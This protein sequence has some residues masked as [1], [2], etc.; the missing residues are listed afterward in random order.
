[1]EEENLIVGVDIGT[2]KISAAAG[3]LQNDGSIKIKGFVEKALKPQDEA[4]RN[5]E[6]ENA[7]RTIDILD[8]VLEELAENVG[9]NLIDININIS[10]PEIS[11]TYHKG[12]VTKSGENKQIQQNDVDKLIEDLRLTNR[13]QPGRTLLHSLPQDFYINDVRAGEKIVGKFGIQ[14]GGEFYFVSTPTESLEKLYY[15]IKSVNAKIE[16][17]KQSEPLQIDQIILS[18]VAD[19]MALLDET[20]DDKRNGVAIVN[21]GAEMTEISIFHKNA[22]RHFKAVALG[23]NN[24]NN[25]LSEAFQ[26]NFDDAEILKKISGNIPSKSVS[27]TEV[28]VINRQKDLAPI[29]IQ[30]KNASNVVEWRLKEIAALVKTEIIRSGYE[31]N[32][33]NGIILTGGTSSMAIIKEIFLDVCKIKTVRKAKIN[34]KINFSGFEMLNKPKYSTL[35]GLLIAAYNDFDNRANNSILNHGKVAETAGASLESSKPNV[36]KKIEKENKP[37]F[38]EKIK[39]FI[40]DD[41]LNDDYNN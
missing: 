21:I 16:D 30:L 20:I 1:M 8:E 2:S 25:D 12:K 6:I 24:I 15:T 41:N 13:P 29:E 17:S 34:N 40:K 3:S 36:K 38:F 5:G 33:T 35:L 22:L 39:T 18:S 27:E 37:S 28:A 10:N 4:I 32:L 23:G 14:V 9:L 19:A 7:Q 31:N 26:I 11:G